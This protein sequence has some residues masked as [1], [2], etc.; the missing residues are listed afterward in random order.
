MVE[1]GVSTGENETIF[2]ECNTMKSIKRSKIGKPAP[3]V[4]E[5]IV[6]TTY[7]ERTMNAIAAVVS[8][9]GGKITP[10]TYQTNIIDFAINGAGHGVV[11]AVP[12]SG[13]STTLEYAVVGL[14]EANRGA[15]PRILVLAFNKAI[16]DAMSARLPWNHCESKTLNALGF[17]IL[18]NDYRTSQANRGSRINITEEKSYLVA[19]GV[20]KFDHACQADQ[21]QFN[22]NISA[23]TKLISLFKNLGYGAIRELP[24]VADVEELADQYDINMPDPVETSL[25]W[26][27]WLLFEAF[28]AGNKNFKIFDY[29]DQLFLPVL[30]NMSIPTY[31]DFIMIDES[32]DLN[33]IQIEMIRRMTRVGRSR[34]IFVGD[35]YQS[36][37]GF[38]GADPKA[39]ESI[40]EI[41][42]PHEM[43]L[44]ISWRCP[45]SVVAEAARIN[46]AIIAAPDAKEGTVETINAEKFIDIIEDNDMVLCR[47]S[48]PLM[49]YC[50][51]L[52]RAGI[53][54][55]IKGTD[56]GVGLQNM[57][58]KIDKKKYGGTPYDQIGVY[59]DEQ[60]SKIKDETKRS[61]MSDRILTL[62]ILSEDCENMKDV[63]RK[64][65]RIFSEG[66]SGVMFSTV[67]KAKGLEKRRV[68]ILHPELMPHPMARSK[69]AQK[70]ERNIEYVAI[71]RA[72]ESLYWVKSK[73]K[74][75][76]RETAVPLE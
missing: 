59:H 41:F 4:A 37:Y 34:A 22:L 2:T 26:F 54:A 62:Q 76:Q 33:P 44:S 55:Y 5:T 48:A 50:L 47:T 74:I 56:I 60:V 24:T 9:T 35:E 69:E 29:N 67:H 58:K 70:Q 15:L 65:E 27:Y 46:P 25:D 28:D 20:M 18:A 6:A 39:I 64:I 45:K 11:K 7:N 63:S 16:A 17:R 10:T 71:T 3:V 14:T 42:K 53:K 73:G 38:R 23:I 61:R 19:K 68:F 30:Y 66:K 12:G 21:D 52:I 75:G 36:I 1:L 72:Q 49:E 8:H 31:Y 13:K 40:S 32:Q 51:D 43:P 57:L